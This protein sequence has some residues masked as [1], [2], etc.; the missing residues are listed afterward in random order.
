MTKFGTALLGC[1]LATWGLGCDRSLSVTSGANDSQEEDWLPPVSPTGPYPRA[2]VDKT[3]HDFG[4]MALGEERKHTF[5]VRNEGEAPLVLKKGRT[6]CKC[7]LSEVAKEEIP[8]GAS[9][10]ITLEWKAVEI[11][12]MYN[13]GAEFGTND[14]D[15][16]IIRLQG[17]GSVQ[18]LFV[19]TPPHVWIIERISDDKPAEVTGAVHS[20]ILD[21]FSIIEP[22]ESSHEHLSAT[23]EPLDPPEREELG[24]AKSGYRIKAVV[25][26]E[27]PVGRFNEELKIHVRYDD[28]ERVFPIR[29][30]GY[31]TGPIVFLP[32]GDVDWRPQHMAVDL[33]RFRASQGAS[34]TL[35]ILVSGLG[36]KELKFEQVE[37]DPDVVRASVTRDRDPTL[38][39]DG[40]KKYRLKF[41]VPPGSPGKSYLRKDAVKVRIRTNHPQAGEMKF[42]VECIID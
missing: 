5:V 15:N 29:V 36:D 24:G 17:T 13:E 10:E 35:V 41:E 20:R 4:T 42:S 27:I 16:R 2:V 3:D 39:T 8:P 26:P 22:I 21:E 12:D 28:Q 18:E 11:T 9:A 34:A 40:R 30:E 14:P 19:T 23:A 25:S 37:S 7:T 38:E 32:A 33:G 6:S 1:L 31:R